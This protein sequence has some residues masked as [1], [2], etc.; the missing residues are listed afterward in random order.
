MSLHLTLRMAEIIKILSSANEFI[1]SDTLALKL[2]VTS[3]TI[4]EDIKTINYKMKE[5]K[6][7]IVSKKSK[8]YKITAESDDQLKKITL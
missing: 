8:G 6:T 1:T 3:R 4:R 2:G 7:E 5:F